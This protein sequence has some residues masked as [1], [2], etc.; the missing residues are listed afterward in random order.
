MKNYKHGLLL[1]LFLVFSS[2]SVVNAQSKANNKEINSVYEAKMISLDGEKIDFSQYKG[3]V[4]LIVNTA[5]KCGFTNQ[6]KGLEELN[7][8][9]SGKGLV[10]LGFP[11]NQFLGQEPGENDE[12]KQFCMANYG[13]SFQMFEKIDVNGEDAVPLYKFLK[14]KAPFEGFKDKEM[15][16]RLMDILKKYNPEYIDGNEIK[17]NFTKFIVSK[18][19]EKII[20]FESPI[21]PEELDSEIEALL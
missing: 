20:R 15:G 19:G 8:K 12:I 13:V 18:D 3:K 10:I 16:N 14:E 5:S 9:Y 21:T 7:K 17:W 4:L 11:C 6:Y 1:G 2:F